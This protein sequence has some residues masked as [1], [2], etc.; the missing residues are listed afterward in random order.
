MRHATKMVALAL[1]AT[2]LASATAGA[3]VV[4]AQRPAA[5]RTEA[6]AAS[7]SSASGTA[8]RTEPTPVAVEYTVSRRGA[9]PAT[10]L[11]GQLV[12]VPF[13][14]ATVDLRAARSNEAV[15]MVIEARP[16]TD[17]S[18]VVHVHWRETSAQGE[19][20][21]WEPA[22]QLRRGAAGT[23]SLDWAGGGR[24]LHLRLR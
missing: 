3:Q 11:T 21:N 2:L 16:Q 10:A 5:P 17:G 22:V 6:S 1:S 8:A 13:R 23:A 20:V 9:Q 15:S 24:T 12:L 4:Q 19:V 7:A 14:S 18:F